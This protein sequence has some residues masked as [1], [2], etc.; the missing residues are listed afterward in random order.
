[1][2]F[3]LWLGCV[4][5]VPHGLNPLQFSPIGALSCLFIVLALAA[6]PT[7]SWREKPPTAEIG[8]R[9]LDHIGLPLRPILLK[10][11]MNCVTLLLCES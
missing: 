11:G 1:M 2:S 7:L 10:L 9:L 6:H 5:G 4:G 8:L 3:M